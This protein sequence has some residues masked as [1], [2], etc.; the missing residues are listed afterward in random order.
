VI[1]KVLDA[2]KPISLPWFMKL[3]NRWRWLQRFPARIVG[4][5][6]RPEHIA[7]NLRKSGR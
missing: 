3:V 6:F 2:S 1:R 5:G 4:V 7:P